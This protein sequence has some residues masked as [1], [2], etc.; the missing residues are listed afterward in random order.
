MPWTILGSVVAGLVILNILVVL[1]IGTTS[2]LQQRRRPD[3]DSELGYPH[4]RSDEA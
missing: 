2:H 4:G 1:L 3:G